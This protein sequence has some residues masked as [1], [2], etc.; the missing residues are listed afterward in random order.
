[1]FALVPV[2]PLSALTDPKTVTDSH[3]SHF[4]HF[5]IA[6]AVATT[7]TTTTQFVCLFF[8]LNYLV[9]GCK[10]SSATAESTTSERIKIQ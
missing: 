1:M 7:A 8:A 3:L 10:R 4:S 6:A 9:Q 5:L 2:L